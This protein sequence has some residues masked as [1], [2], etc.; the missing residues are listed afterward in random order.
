M[1]GATCA[2]VTIVGRRS[3]GPSPAH[4]GCAE[5]LKGESAK[6]GCEVSVSEAR[7]IVESPYGVTAFECPHGITLFMEPTGDQ[8][9]V[10]ARD[11]VA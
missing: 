4:D 2:T 7:P 3:T 8:I 5:F 9:A 10:W 6:L 11:G 1:F